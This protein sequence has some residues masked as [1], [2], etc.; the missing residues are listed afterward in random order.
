MTIIAK[1]FEG[2]IPDVCAELNRLKL[3]NFNILSITHYK[4]QISPFQ[5]TSP[6]Q[7]TI[8]FDISDYPSIINFCNKLKIQP[9]ST[10]QWF[11]DDNDWWEQPTNQGEQ[12]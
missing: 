7:T 11:N 6:Y 9:P 3:Y 2:Q 10:S 5:N 12:K 8:V 1:T 4:S